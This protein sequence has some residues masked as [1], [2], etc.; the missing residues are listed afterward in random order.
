MGERR[1]QLDAKIAAAAA[2]GDFEELTA[3]TQQLAKLTANIDFKTER[4][5]ELAERAEG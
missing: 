1:E 2:A 4:W 5:L 3:A